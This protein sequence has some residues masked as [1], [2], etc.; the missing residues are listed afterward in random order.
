MS[1]PAPNQNVENEKVALEGQNGSGHSS[2]PSVNSD[3]EYANPT[4]IN[5]KALIRRLDLK[6]LPPLTL[7]YLLS[8]LDR[9]NSM[10]P[11]LEERRR[12]ADSATNSRQCEVGWLDRHEEEGWFERHRQSVLAFLD[13]LL[14]WIC[15]FVCWNRRPWSDTCKVLFEIPCNIVLKRTTPKKWLPTLMLSWGIVATCL[16]IAQSYPGFVVARF[17]LGVTESGLFPGVVFYLSMW[18]KRTETHFRVAL[19]F[20]AAS[21]A[22]A[23]GG[24]LAYGIGFMDGVGGYKGWRWIFI[25]VSLPPQHL[26]QTNIHKGRTPY[27]S[28]LPR[29]LLLH[30]QLPAY[31]PLPHRTRTSHHPRPSKER[32]RRNESG[33]I[34]LGQCARRTRRLQM[35]ALRPRI[36]HHV[37]TFVYTLA[38]P[39]DYHRGPRVHS[40]TSP[41]PNCASL[42]RGNYP[43]SHRRG[44][45]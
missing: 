2:A 35:L 33:R 12:S 16:G 13:Y 31:R 27:S 40:R 28:H 19:F 22:G 7:L 3:E 17:F 36:P 11:Y 5:E 6:L 43:H 24:I 39:P 44:P 26:E 41:T 1:M 37:F 34:L 10:F 8:F 45:R 29:L 30:P 23:F 15:K 9:S 25:I 20:S 4:G 21:L 14:R 38:L 32:L 42:C 18:Y